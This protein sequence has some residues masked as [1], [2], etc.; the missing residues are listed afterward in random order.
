MKTIIRAVLI[1]AGMASNVLAGDIYMS[2]IS[3][4]EKSWIYY[5]TENRLRKMP[6]WDVKAGK[7]IPVTVD[8]AVEAAVNSPLAKSVKLTRQDVS[9]IKLHATFSYEGQNYWQY[10]IIF[11]KD[12]DDEESDKEPFVVNVM[13]DGNVPLRMS[14]KDWDRIQRNE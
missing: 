3:V 11:L 13:M 9:N 6:R 10:E 4:N 1:A 5:L 7:P 2:T 12:S 14:S 8:K